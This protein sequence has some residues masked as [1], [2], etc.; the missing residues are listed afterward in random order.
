MLSQPRLILA[1][2]SRYRRQLLEQLGLAFE[3]VA[4][5]YDEE[6]A[7]PLPPEQ[8]VVELAARKARS[9]G[10]AYPDEHALILGA[11]QVAEAEG[12]LLLKPGSAERA[13]AQLAELAGRTHRLLTGIALF[14]PSTGRLEQALCVHRMTM[15]PLDAAQ[16]A[17]Y[18]EREQP[19]DCAGAY[20]V[21]GLGIA[22]FAVMSGDDHTGIIGLPLTRVLDLLARFGWPGPL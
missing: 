17:A 16:I 14:Q 2:T 1:S 3:A 22:L 6:H 5:P 7:L 18:V 20:K 13:R 19:L 21:E 4:P 11:D 10:P 8:L 15:R 9:L 12:R